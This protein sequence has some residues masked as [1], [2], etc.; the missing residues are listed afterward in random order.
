MG[1]DIYSVNEEQDDS[2]QQV[3]EIPNNVDISDDDEIHLVHVPFYQPA[4][5]YVELNCIWWTLSFFTLRA[6]CFFQEHYCGNIR[7]RHCPPMH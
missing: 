1:F 7:G 4:A 2:K 3:I 5:E 6:I